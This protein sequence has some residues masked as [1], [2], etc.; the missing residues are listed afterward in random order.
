[1]KIA[2]QRIHIAGSANGAA[3]HEVLVYATFN[4]ESE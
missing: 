4:R 3:P 2:G 1:M